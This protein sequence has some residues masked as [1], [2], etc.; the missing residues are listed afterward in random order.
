MTTTAQLLIRVVVQ[1]CLI[2]IC[3]DHNQYNRR[4][5]KFQ[6]ALL[7]RIQRTAFSTCKFGAMERDKSKRKKKLD[8]I[9]SVDSYIVTSCA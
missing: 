4:H 9:A 2:L 8:W 6:S 5:G 3:T 7:G 1:P